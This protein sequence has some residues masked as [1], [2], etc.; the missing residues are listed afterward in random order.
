MSFALQYSMDID[1][2]IDISL[3]IR[4]IISLAAPGILIKIR[5]G[6]RIDGNISMVISS[7][8][9]LRWCI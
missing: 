2:D 3:A 1:L 8:C 6:I 5:F 4:F 7:W 9:E